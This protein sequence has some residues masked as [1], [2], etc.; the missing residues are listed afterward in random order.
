MAGGAFIGVVDFGCS[1]R[2]QESKSCDIQVERW[3]NET[4][5]MELELRQGDVSWRPPACA[6]RITT[7]TCTGYSLSPAVSSYNGARPK[8]VMED[9]NVLEVKSCARQSSA[10]HSEPTKQISCSS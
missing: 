6:M 7:T 4:V 1:V 5:E 2:Y 8:E 3:R 10:T 9:H